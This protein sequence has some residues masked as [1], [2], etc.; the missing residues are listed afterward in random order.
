MIVVPIDELLEFHERK[1]GDYAIAVRLDH[2]RELKKSHDDWKAE[3]ER[4]AGIVA[5]GS[6]EVTR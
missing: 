6:V 5:A 2:L 1:P 3:A 4:L